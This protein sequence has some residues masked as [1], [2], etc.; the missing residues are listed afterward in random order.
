M[1]F[2]LPNPTQPTFHSLLR[3]VAQGDGLTTA[4]LL[5]EDDFQQACDQFSVHF[6][7]EPD[8][9]W[10]P[11]LTLW[12]FLWQ[13]LSPAKSCVAAVARAL[14]WRIASGLPPCS[15]NTGAY[16]KARQKLPEQLLS[17]LTL[18][19][20]DR[21]EQDVPHSWLWHGHHVYLIDGNVV[22]AADTDANQ[23]VYPQR[24]GQPGGVGFPL[25]RWVALLSWATGA[26][27]AAAVGPYQGKQSGETSLARTLLQRLQAGAILLGDRLFATY[28]L[29]ALTRQ[30]QAHGVFR[31]HAH[32][33]RNGNGQSSRLQGRLGHQDQLLLWKRPARP[34][35]MD[36]ATYQQ[37]PT[38][39]LVRVCWRP[40]AIPGF[41]TEEVV[42]VTTLL[43]AEVYPAEELV[44]LYRQ[45]WHA[46]LDLR[47]LK[48]TLRMEHLV[49]KTPE[50]VRKELWM[51]L[52]GYNLI[53]QVQVQAAR[54]QGVLPR[55]LSFAGTLQTV[56]AMRELL[57]WLEGPQRQGVVLALWT[58]VGQHRVANRPN[59]VEPRRIKRSPKPYPRLRQNRAAARQAL[60][61]GQARQ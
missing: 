39:L 1:P 20:G 45:R 46:E 23:T 50:M 34:E 38:E 51:H 12:T 22:T 59:R 8:A 43:D 26:C 27:T 7:A 60:R 15:A 5:T 55:Q 16:C 40:V 37:M 13:V 14:V 17:G 3:S 19:V 21:L 44:G 61:T 52:L 56:T 2:Y 9:V 6:A 42:V 30:R 49:C 35:W 48:S 28:W 24:R 31:L 53:R 47:S 41:R 29:I 4:D 57:S 36:E 58:A 54:T 33:Q 25:L 18:L 10:T 32:R 11:V